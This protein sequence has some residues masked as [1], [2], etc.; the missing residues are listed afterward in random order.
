M[1]FLPKWIQ[2]DGLEIFVLEGLSPEMIVDTTALGQIL[3]KKQ[4]LKKLVFRSLDGIESDSLA[5]LIDLVENIIRAGPLRL[6]EIDLGG[7]GGSKEQGQQLL[8]A[9]S[10][11]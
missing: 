6:K 10:E 3:Q 7:I 8:Q 5:K 9:L 11:T 4:E 2:T 1:Y